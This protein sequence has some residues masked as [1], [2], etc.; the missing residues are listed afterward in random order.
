MPAAIKIS[1]QAEER[2]EL[3]KLARAN[4]R[5]L[6]EKTRARILLL[7][8]TNREEGAWKVEAIRTKLRVS[9]PTV[10]RVK[11]AFLERGVESVFRKEQQQR[12][13][14][15]LGGEAEAFL[16][17]SVC[18]EAPKGRK[19]WTLELLQDKVIAAGYVDGVA[20]ETIRQTLKKTNSSLG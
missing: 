2:T 1:L 15:V 5:S 6:R 10:V 8:D 7:S 17:A 12:K 18:S 3:E 20:K 4:K 13:V 19:R 14:R 16:I 9:P 11:K